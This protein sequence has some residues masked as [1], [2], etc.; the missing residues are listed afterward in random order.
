M[1]EL[2]H[3]RQQFPQLEHVM[4]GRGLLADPA[5]AERLE[6]TAVGANICTER[7]REFHDELYSEYQRAF[8]GEKPVLFKMKELWV[9]WGEQFPGEDKA[10]KQIRKA[11]RLA[12]YESAARYLLYR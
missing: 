8:S 7:F 4:I 6:T 10:L 9:Y 5:L 1:E 12:D 2:E 3:L 11:Q